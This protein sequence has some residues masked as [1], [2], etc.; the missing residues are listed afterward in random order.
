MII[1]FA[2]LI[3]ISVFESS[4]EADQ[5]LS[6]IVKNNGRLDV[7]Q[8]KQKLGDQYNREGMFKYRYFTANI[9][10]K[11]QKMKVIDDGHIVGNSI[12]SVNNRT[13]QLTLRLKSGQMKGTI[14]SKGMRFRYLA[15]KISANKYYVCFIDLSP[16]MQ[17][18]ILLAK[19]ALI[20]TFG[21]ILFF[22]VIMALL[23]DRAVQP[24]KEAYEKQ[25]RFITNAGHEL[26]TPLAVISANAEME[27]IL[28][29]DDEWNESTK[30]QVVRMTGLINQLITLTRM[31]EPEEI[32]LSKIN[33]S[34]TAKQSA[35]SFKSVLAKDHKKYTVNI[36][37]DLYVNAE[38]H[39]LLELVNILIDNAQKYCDPEG[40]VTVNLTKSRLNQN[41][42]LTVS[43][44]YKNG[45][46]VDTNRFFER[47][48]REDE[49]HHYD[50]E[51]KSGFGIG[52]SM[53]QDLVA[54]FGGKINAN[55]SDGVMN[56][57][58]TFK[59]VH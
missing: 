50:H 49:S 58:V 3:G 20:F 39:S 54:T 33:F 43:N 27:E 17:S 15:K 14:R 8:A 35:E 31:S 45:A 52:L 13:K 42:V 16:L 18:T 9:N 51:K 44:S 25:R 4:R 26:K 56:F 48:Y 21:G 1:S 30:E 11:T 32:V 57:T 37:P 46:D 6:I 19:Y 55:W 29:N 22:I 40:E 10:T 28:G 34:E 7:V 47:F 23:A 38:Q 41:A 53:A 36:D 12:S 2:S 59:R 24:I 5:V